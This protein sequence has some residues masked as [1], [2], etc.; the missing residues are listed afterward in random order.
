M[1]KLSIDE[2][3]AIIGEC[4]SNTLSTTDA[5]LRRD[6]ESALDHY[7][8]RPYGNEIDGRSQ[9]V[10]KDLMDIIECEPAI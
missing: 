1:P 6:R 8:G 10:T 9:V 7:Y 4:L 2:Q 5:E 3:R